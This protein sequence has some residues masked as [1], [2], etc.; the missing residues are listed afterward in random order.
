MDLEKLYQHYLHS[1]TVSTDSRQITPGCIFFALKGEHFNGNRFALQAL[2][3]GAAAAVVDED[4]GEPHPALFRT[5]SVL[6]ALQDLAALHRR[7][8]GMTILAIT[9]SNGKTTTKE[10]VS[11]VLAKRF[12][13]Y[14]TRGNLNNHIGVPLTLLAMRPEVEMGIVEMGAN[15]PGEIRDLCA[16]AA[17]DAGLITN[18]GKAHLEG[19]GS[20]EGVAR[21][22]GE[23]FD[24]LMAS[25][26]PLFLNEGNT[27]LRN[28]IPEHYGRADRYNGSGSLRAVRKSSDPFLSLTVVVS[29]REETVE[30]RL[31]GQYNAENVLAACCV[32]LHYGIPFTDIREAIAGYTPQNN[33]SQLIATNRNRLYMDAYNANPSSMRAALEE[34]LALEHPRKMLILG[35]MREL[36]A[37]SREEHAALTGYIRDHFIGPVYCIGKAFGDLPDR[38]HFTWFEAAGDLAAHLTEAPPADYFILIKGSRSNQLEKIAAVL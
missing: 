17:P 25:G 12:R 15:H 5:E 14:A 36:G 18:V 33:R 38:N 24:Y 28:L 1:R 3:D 6:Q 7:R 34:F 11:A 8:S 4:P 26:K 23:L 13:V 30:T 2:K 21:A 19:F 29:G 16:I 27:L 10:L 32:G 35:E 9:G 31:L 22:K 37:S 20:L